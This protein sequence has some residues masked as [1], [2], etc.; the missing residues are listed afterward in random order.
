[1]TTEFMSLTRGD[2]DEDL[3]SHRA[4]VEW[5]ISTFKRYA[6]GCAFAPGDLITPRA[7]SNLEG[8]GL[9]HIVLDV[10]APDQAKPRMTGDPNDASFGARIDVRYARLVSAPAGE[11]MVIAFWEESWKFEPYRGP[12]A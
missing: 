2:T 7:D 10:V 11:T 4:Q 1:M 6:A 9:P 8:A 12:T 5:L 3:P